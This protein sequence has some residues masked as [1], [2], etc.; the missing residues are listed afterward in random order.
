MSL[1]L[2]TRDDD[3]G[4]GLVA[5]LDPRSR[6]LA[7]GLFAL[8]LTALPHVMPVLLGLGL[9]LLT[10]ALA[11]LP[12]RRTLRRLAALD[13]II[14]LAV[15]LL[16]F[17]VPGDTVFTLLGQGASAQGL[18]QGALIL[19]KANAVTLMLLAL[20]GSMDAARLGQALG[21]LGVPEK[22]VQ[23]LLFTVRYL[24]VLHQEYARL[25][26]A[27]RARGFVLTT[28]PHGWRTIGTL[29][30]MV[31]VRSAERAER[32]VAAM[33]CRGFDGRFPHLEEPSRFRSCDG[34]F[35]LASVACLG[36]LAAA[37]V[38]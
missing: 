27:L 15:A 36:L 24:D 16:P 18:H 22:L 38:A 7:A 13:G 25:R 37:G 35:A 32:I 29:F 12:L 28:S 31:M 4:L 21:R 23:L 33:R 26:T 9:A 19:A 2:L 14:L 20:V 5:R 8:L 3:L 6:V 1:L 17:T 34:A 11:R 30:G 10:A